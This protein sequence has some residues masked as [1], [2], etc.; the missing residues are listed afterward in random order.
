MTV[1][2][3][4]TKKAEGKRLR[5]VRGYKRKIRGGKKTSVSG[6][7]QRYDKPRG[8]RNVLTSDKQT[9]TSKTMWLKDRKGRFVGRANYKGETKAKGAVKG[10]YDL[11][12]LERESGTYGRIYG[13]YSE[14]TARRRRD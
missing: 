6:Y 7:Y 10:E 11:T 14:S 1:K 4:T 3:T 9:S 8:K 12:D 13:R 2:K 5:E